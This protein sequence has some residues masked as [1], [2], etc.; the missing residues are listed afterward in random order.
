MSVKKLAILLGSCLC[1][2]VGAAPC[3]ILEL[4][5][6]P[7]EVL[8]EMKVSSSNKT[9]TCFSQAPNTI[10]SYTATDIR[11][12]GARTLSD[13]LWLV[14]GMQVQTQANN[15]DK[16]WIRGV[17]SEFNNK[18]A[19]YIDSVPIRDVFGG[20]AIDEEIPVESIE[21][22]EIIR[23]PGAA[24]YGAN[25]F[26]GVIN[27]FTFQAGKHQ[28]QSEPKQL[29]A[30]S[31]NSPAKNTLKLGIGE[32]NT[33]SSYGAIEHTIKDAVAARLEAKWLKTD[34]R[35]PDFDRTGQPNSRP[36]QQQLG[37]AHLNLTALDGELVFNSTYSD[38]DNIRVDKPAP[39]Y[40]LLN[41]QNWRF[42]LAYQHQF[43][44]DLGIDVHAYH[45]N[46]QR[47]ENESIYNK[48]SLAMTEA[49]RFIDVTLLTG[50]Y[51]AV[52][53]L[54][55]AGNRLTSG[56]EVKREQLQKSEFTDKLTGQIHSFIQDKR[57]EKL[58]LTNYGFFV[59]DIQDIFSSDTQ[60]TIG[61]RYDVL[62][63]FENQFSYR[64]GLT[65]SFNENFYAKLLYGTAYR[66]PNF[67][68]FT[69]APV[70]SQ[71]PKV[72]TMKTL[73]A[74]LGFQGE[75]GRISLTGYKNSYHDFITRK[76]SFNGSS[77]YL[78]D[79][80]FAN[81]DH[82][83][84]IGAEL[85]SQLF[86]NKNWQLFLNASWSEA[87][88]LNEQQKLPLLADWTVAT[89]VEWRETFGNG[90]LSFNNHIITYG[91]RRDWQPD[92]WNA[93]QQQR[94]PN[95]NSGLTDGFAI[96]NSALHYNLP[97]AKQQAIDFDLSVHNILNEKIYTQSLVPPA[98]NKIAN[99]DTQYQGRQLRFAISY[100]W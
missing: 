48:Q 93:G 29:A 95:R 100:S 60:L 87:K 65:H 84:I 62:E 22:I 1:A 20:F 47:L 26:S 92:L 68:E 66:A 41:N 23:G 32:N 33:Y 46:T 83:S 7:I 63:L 71:L 40:N 45:T 15:R 74:Q 99:F 18:I 51:G 94:Y 70:N 61:L 81:I 59:Q 4:V 55:V 17:Q 89:G 64:L 9:P 75:L 30:S 37:Y 6:T 76:N 50:F 12:L 36:A 8:L 24:L 69:R 58:A 2:P 77:T 57:Y 88:S 38:F 78:P 31:R 53:Y 25:A 98:K 80:V 35:K 16:V 11:H 14:A 56:F 10:S 67:V 82:L 5:E 97:V 90:E 28:E 42:S 21:K 79:E 39:D 3:N 85:E 86:L 54:P 27:I 49:S 91:K 19:L 72:E 44:S 34:N 13:I 96:W 52:N 73:E 43:D